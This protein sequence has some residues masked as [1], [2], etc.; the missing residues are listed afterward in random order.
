MRKEARYWFAGA[1]GKYMLD[2]LLATT[3]FK[4]TSGARPDTP[5]IFTLWHGRLLPLTYF[6]RKQNIATLISQSSDGEYIA[7]V[8]ERWGYKAIR[9]SSSRGGTTAL[10]EMVKVARGGRSMAIT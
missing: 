2:A 4:V 7:R 5:V 10:R 3:R 6:H 8:V 9:G 1:L